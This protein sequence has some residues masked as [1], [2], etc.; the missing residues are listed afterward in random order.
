MDIVIP[1]YGRASYQLQH[2]ARLLCTAGL[3]PTL[4][5]R[6]EQ[7]EAYQTAL[8]RLEGQVQ[9]HTLPPQ[10]KGVSA[11]RDYIVHDMPSDEAH[12]VMLDDDLH[13]AVRRTDDPTKFRQPLVSDIQHMMDSIDNMLTQFPH[14][15]IGS[16]EGGNRVTDPI[17][18]NTRMMRVLAYERN[19][20]RRHLITF[21]PMECMEDFHVTL[22]LLRAGYDLPVLNQWVS[23]QAGG[24]DAEGGCST[25]RTREV[26]RENAERL[27]KLH[28]GFV[29][30][31]TKQNKSA[32]GGEPRTDVVVQWKRARESYDKMKGI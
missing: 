27:A 6:P 15:S 26:Q 9:Y 30:C 11:A 32:W 2:T 21:H 5:V 10:C 17:T 13:F 3:R 18:W 8:E 29:K 16:R 23:N 20:M 7:L 4:V 19:V 28:P 12:V 1:T 24:S 25:F 14:C 22:K 31:V